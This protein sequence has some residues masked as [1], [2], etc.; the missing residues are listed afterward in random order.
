MG[1]LVSLIFLVGMSGAGGVILAELYDAGKCGEC[2]EAV[3]I[4]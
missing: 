2:C 1:G 3:L 4:N